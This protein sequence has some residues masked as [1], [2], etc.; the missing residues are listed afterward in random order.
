M[1]NTTIR[2]TLPI[3]IKFAKRGSLKFIGHLDTMR[4]FQKLIRRA[5]IDIAYSEGFNPHQKM[6]F[7]S[8]L[9]V[10]LCSEGEYVDIEVNT[11]FCSKEAVARLNS[12]SVDGIEIISYRSLPDN[13][14][15]AMASVEAA[16]YLV[17]FREDYE[18]TSDELASFESFM[19]QKSINVIKQTKKSEVEMDILPFIY[20][21]Y[22]ED[23]ALILK[24]ASGSVNNIKPELVV[25]A[26]YAYLG[27]DF[28]E[29]ALLI[30]RLEVY[31]N[32]GTLEEPN[33]IPLEDFGK[34]VC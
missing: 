32:N 6:S 26:F 9:G 5:E 28:N 7:A 33:F 29:L 27:K 11:T 16:D 13:A 25:Q 17:D 20:K 4:Y 8:P 31:G 22:I 18:L 21:W 30:T 24:L 10:G 19:E 34:E 14:K 15:N 12:Q 1:N 23:D 2:E 3:R